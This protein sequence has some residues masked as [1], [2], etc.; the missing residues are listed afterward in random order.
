[1]EIIQKNKIKRII[2]DIDYTLITPNYYREDVFFKEQKLYLK[3]TPHVILTE[4]EKRYKRYTKKQL[5]YFMN[6][7][8]TEP[9]DKDFL[10]KWM[11]FTT[12]LDPQDVSEVVE[13]LAYLKEKKLDL[14]ALSNWFTW[15]QAKKLEQ[16][17]MLSY[18]TKVYGG[19]YFIKPHKESFL[20]ASGPYGMDEC[21]MIG[22]NP[23]ADIK[24]AEN[25]GMPAIWYTEGREEEDYKKP[26]I[27][28][29]SDLK[30]IF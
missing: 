3:E 13:T 11:V 6:Q 26:K 18:F 5:L 14:A 10:E 15:V 29:I 7:Y 21:V 16:V 1:M 27:K 2:I 24:G 4:Y 23:I 8:S 9:I 17:K 12:E 20:L 28:R 30:Q 19:D 25:V 22:D